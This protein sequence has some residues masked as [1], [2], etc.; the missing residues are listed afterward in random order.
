MADFKYTVDPDFDH[1]IDEKGNTFVALRKIKWGDNSEFKLDLRKYYETAE[2]ERMN[3]GVS[4][5]DEGADELTKVLLQEGYGLPSD[6]YET[7]KENRPDVLKK[8]KDGGDL[9]D[10]IEITKVEE[11]DFYDPR[12]MLDDEIS[13]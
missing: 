12:E 6:I 5:T 13:V 3:K 1:T 4:F 9:N 8:F 2:G 11:D 7:I 10:D